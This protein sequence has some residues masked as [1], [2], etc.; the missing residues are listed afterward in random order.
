MDNNSKFIP[1]FVA[2]FLEEASEIHP[3]LMLMGPRQSGKTTLLKRIFPNHEYITLRDDQTRK[4]ARSNPAFF[5]DHLNTPVIVDDVHLAPSL[6]ESLVAL[7]ASEIVFASSRDLV[8]SDEAIDNLTGKLAVFTL[9]PLSL[10]EID[11]VGD[12]PASAI[13]WI[14]E[15]GY[16]GSVAASD[17][18]NSAEYL[19]GYMRRFILPDVKLAS[20]LGK[21][22]DFLKFAAICARNVGVPVN[23]DSMAK[24]LGINIRTALHW[25]EVLQARFLTMTLPAYEQDVLKYQVKSPKLYF[26]DTGLAF[27]FIADFDTE[28]FVLNNYMQVLFENAV[29]VEIAKSF[30][31]EGRVPRLSYWRDSMGREISLMV[32]MSDD[33]TLA[34]QIAATKRCDSKS[35]A[36][37][38]KIA[39]ELGIPPEHRM[40]VYMGNKTTQTSR[41]RIVSYKQIS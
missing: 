17:A 5:L 24:E 23:M 38:D 25:H 15:G 28:N 14:A 22:N 19:K 31:E 40:I 20:E 29:I 41:G 13:E 30:Y 12:A 39:P 37:L 11:E 8:L 33:V 1:R 26:C 18:A 21:L 3:Y 36:T 6:L 35:F 27:D 2:S 7:D 9:P 16:P 34:I 32:E 10:A 4:E